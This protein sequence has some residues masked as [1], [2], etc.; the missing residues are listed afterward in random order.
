MNLA[1]LARP[2]KLMTAEKWLIFSAVLCFGILYYQG[3]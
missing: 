3:E 1:S 2:G